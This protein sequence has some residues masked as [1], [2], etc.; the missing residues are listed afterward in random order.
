MRT[1]RAVCRSRCFLA[2]ALVLWTA[3]ASA[4]ETKPV[5]TPPL[6]FVT[7]YVRQLA[8][9]EDT[10]AQ[11]EQE[12]KKAAKEGPQAAMREAIYVSTRIQLELRDQIGR[13]RGMHLSKEF[14]FIVPGIIAYD[15]QKI[16]L[17]QS[18]I[19]IAQ[20]FVEGP[21]D[22]VDYGKLAAEMPKVRAELD[23]TDHNL[24]EVVPGV[25]MTLVDQRPDSKGHCS[26]LL[27]T[28]AEA[29]KLLADLQTYFGAKLEE[30]NPPY[31][32]GSAQIMKD[33]LLKQWKY[34]DDPWE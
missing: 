17:H 25:L 27:I 28:R 3:S 26:H 20:A 34:A 24:M 32:V 13:L 4:Q 7:E 14:D 12:Y 2:S 15:E 16:E 31:L 22:G 30:K 19:D 23:Q 9:I 5:E 21:K 29:A 1:L 8:Q 6:A 33:G 11:L 18:I 10:R